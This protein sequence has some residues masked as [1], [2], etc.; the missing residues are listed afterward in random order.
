MTNASTTFDKTTPFPAHIE[1]NSLLSAPTSHKKTCHISLN[2][3]GSGITYLPGDAL[4]VWAK[5]PIDTVKEVLHLAG[6]NGA[7]LVQEKNGASL[8]LQHALQHHCELGPLSRLFL[9]KWQ[10]RAQS[11]V[12]QQLIREKKEGQPE[13]LDAFLSTNNLFTLLK[14]YPVKWMNAQDFYNAMQ[15]MRP[16][17]YSIASSSNYRKDRVDLIVG[18]VHYTRCDRERFGLCSHY[19]CSASVGQ[20]IHIYIK[21]TPGFRLPEPQKNIIMV[22]AGTGIA[23]FRAFLQERHHQRAQGESWLFFGNRHAKE[24][25]FYAHDMEFFLKEGTL[26]QLDTAFSRDQT[27]KIYVQDRMLENAQKLWKWI[28]NGAHLYLCGDALHLAK[29]VNEALLRIIEEE[30]KLNTEESQNYV[31]Q[32]RKEKRYCLDVY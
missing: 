26:S 10:K 28:K 22:G 8:P 20:K 17:L 23:P 31:K 2:L 25:F 27:H 1:Q 21:E 16:R 11:K 12:L 29:G 4:G 24:D 30:G 15:P 5:H 3:K 13:P 32:L 18:E 19:L 9:I 7:N 14:D 6:L